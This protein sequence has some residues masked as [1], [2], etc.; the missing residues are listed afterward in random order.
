V[1]LKEIADQQSKRHPWEKVR[2]K[3][4]QRIVKEFAPESFRILD[5]GCGDGYIAQ[6]LLKD[7][8]PSEYIG[9]DTNLTSE[10]I[11]FYNKK[12]PE[13][14]FSNDGKYASGKQFDLV[15][16][17]DV[18]EHIEDDEN[19]IMQIVSENLVNNSKMLITVPAFP[20][21]YGSHDTLLG[22]HRRYTQNKLKGIVKKSNCKT[23]ASGYMFASLLVVR[24]ISIILQK[25][26]L[27]K[28]PDYS[29]VG[30]WNG[31]SLLSNVI[32]HALTVDSQILFSASKSGL[33]IP[34]LTLWTLC[35][36]QQ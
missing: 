36:K 10:Q 30:Q 25:I 28:E 17:L 34:G 33:M 11:D 29:G 19:F 12:N 2:A 15:L 32:E 8:S 35:E 5:I 27:L 7:L 21:L 26:S 23:L 6:Q 9:I 24:S 20:F 31:S 13:V 18:I 22:H 4:I 3:F 16:L 1:D 14:T